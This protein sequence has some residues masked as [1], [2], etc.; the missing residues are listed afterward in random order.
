MP[1]GGAAT[2]GDEVHR[3]PRAVAD[4]LLRRQDHR[5]RARLRD[6]EARHRGRPGERCRS[7][8]AAC[9]A[10]PALEHVTLNKRFQDLALSPDGRKVVVR[11]ARRDLGGVSARRRRRGPR[12][13]HVARESQID[14]TPD[15]R[16][17]VYVSERDGAPHCSSTISRRRR[18]DAA[19]ERRDRRRGAACLAGRQALAFV[20]DGKEMR[21][22]DLAAKQERVLAS[23]L[24]RAIDSRAWRG[25]PTAAGSPTSGSSGPSFTERLRRARGRRREPRG[26]RACRTATPTTLSWSPD[27]TYIIFN[28]NQRTEAGRSR[29]ASI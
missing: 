24:S 22:L 16:R 10:A 28:T 5:V 18:G 1:L 11:R 19:D 29:F 23:G 9:R 15:S 2:A 26:Q 17:I 13:A 4:D 6:L 3:R 20:R 8:S 21:V 14:W 12:D 27:G 7:R 25:R